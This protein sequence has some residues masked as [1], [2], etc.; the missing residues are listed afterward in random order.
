MKSDGC[1]CGWR[2]AVYAL[3]AAALLVSVFVLIQSV[4]VFLQSE[5]TSRSGGGGAFHSHA[6]PRPVSALTPLPLNKHLAHYKN[7]SVN[8]LLQLSPVDQKNQLTR[9]QTIEATWTNWIDLDADN[10]HLF[11]AVPKALDVSGVKALRKFKVIDIDAIQLP[12]TAY[13]NMMNALVNIYVENGSLAD[14][15]V[16]ANDHTFLVPPNL[17]GYLCGENAQRAV[18]GGNRLQRGL[19][20]D[21]FPL[22]F[23]SGGAGILLSRPAVLMFFLVMTLNDDSYL[24]QKIAA[25]RKSGICSASEWENAISPQDNLSAYCF[26]EYL[27]AWKQNAASGSKV[28]IYVSSWHTTFIGVL[29]GSLPNQQSAGHLV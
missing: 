19:Y 24:R 25:L 21:D 8:I 5:P 20:K 22:Y 7:M 12:G 4:H 13:A 15:L 9:L 17:Y 11:A 27:S 14:W 18:Y 29:V 2:R 6:R 3:T 28:L 10:F 1:G 23:A 26:V 16:M